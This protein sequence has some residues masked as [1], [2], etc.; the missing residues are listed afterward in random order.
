MLGVEY[1]SIPLHKFIEGAA[2]Q[3][4]PIVA[5]KVAFFISTYLYIL[6]LLFL[7]VAGGYYYRSHARG[8]GG[9][10]A[11]GSVGSP[12]VDSVGSVGSPA[13][14]DSS[15]GI[16]PAVGQTKMSQENK[17]SSPR[18]DSSSEQTEQQQHHQQSSVALQP[19]VPTSSE[20]DKQGSGDVN[21]NHI[22]T[23]K[24]TEPRE[25]DPTIVLAQSLDNR[26]IT[27]YFNE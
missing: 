26:I 2:V 4:L 13:G 7:C 3:F 5:L 14:G 27:N 11:G 16:P 19:T 9:S 15:Q 20:N 8:S 21:D 6:V 10:T 1:G 12:T 23:S 25:E 17:G 24:L 22:L 18:N